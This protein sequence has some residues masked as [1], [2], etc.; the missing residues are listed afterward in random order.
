M[1]PTPR[2]WMPLAALLVV[3]SGCA[4][5]TMA[6]SQPIPFEAVQGALRLRLAKAELFAIA[7]PPTAV[8]GRGESVAVPA[9]RARVCSMLTNC[10]PTFTS[11]GSH[12]IQGDALMEVFADRV[13][14]RPEHRVYY[15]RHAEERLRVIPVPL[16][17]VNFFHRSVETEVE[18][19]FVLIDELTEQVEA[20]VHRPARS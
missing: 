4:Y 12:P 7:G 13:T 18:E 8:A 15:Y 14:L 11:G 9:L 10:D 16:L 6:T 20:I 5:T 3:W 1:T 19:L 2:V 17:L